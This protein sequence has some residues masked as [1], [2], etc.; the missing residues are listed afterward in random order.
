ML[1][2]GLCLGMINTG[3]TTVTVWLLESAKPLMQSMFGTSLGYVG[4][5]VLAN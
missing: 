3:A 1:G 5:V 4:H 2:L